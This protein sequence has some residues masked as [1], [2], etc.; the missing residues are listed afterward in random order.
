MHL[1]FVHTVAKI[2]HAASAPSSPRLMAVNDDLWLRIKLLL[3]ATNDNLIAINGNQIAIKWPLN[4]KLYE[5]A[6]TENN[7]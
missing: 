6:F 4:G 5:W 1:P 2:R 7:S 3:F